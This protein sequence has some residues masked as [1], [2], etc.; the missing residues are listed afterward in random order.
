[1]V[2]EET[3]R[4]G[5]FLISCNEEFV[6]IAR[7]SEE[8]PM[9]KLKPRLPVVSAD[10][11][12]A[13]AASP[14]AAGATDASRLRLKLKLAAE[15]VVTPVAPA[16]PAAP[17]DL[18]LPPPAMASAESVESVPV[19][20]L[21]PRSSVSASP[22]TP[23]SEVPADSPSLLPPPPLPFPSS[24]PSAPANDGD[25]IK[26]KL[27]PKTAENSPPPPSPGASD[28][29]EASSPKPISVP[30]FPV[31]APPAGDGLRPPLA[32]HIRA[33]KS[34]VAADEAA[35]AEIVIAPPRRRKK[36]GIG[37][38]LGGLVLLA[39]AGGG[40]YLTLLHFYEAP[41]VPAK[42]Q[43]KVTAKMPQP[44]AAANP[45]SG[46]TSSDTLNAIAA[47]PGKLI[48][49][50]QDAVAG[51][52]G[53][54][55]A[56]VDAMLEGKDFSGPGALRTPLPGELGGRKESTQPIPAAPAMGRVTATTA[57]APGV[58]VTTEIQASREAS[59]AFRSFITEAKVTGVYQGSP[60]RAFI[61]GRLV[62]VG[63]MLDEGMAIT[64][65]GIDADNRMLL[66]EDR[67]GA[68]VSK[69]Y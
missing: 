9:L 30:P 62:R 33:P 43:P 19:I 63:Q 54:E 22:A 48:G 37:T 1:M 17:V 35:V 47:A 25:A 41:V 44:K 14:A 66:F 60:P 57:I 2:A 23:V 7:M 8:T 26:F 28:S 40:G 50:A 56:R 5:I 34:E 46:P 10:A 51:R 15:P 67:S 24:T 18:S 36:S 21:R 68:R 69:R 11:A 59:P 4:E 12:P 58:S 61:N 6:F 3:D 39:L 32:I 49:S 29:G 53:N 27:K 42:P 13:S 65:D 52:R 38:L 45:T 31:M 20:K 64:F 55:Q 16:E